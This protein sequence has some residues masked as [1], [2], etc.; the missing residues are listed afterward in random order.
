MSPT[1]R[2][3]LLV[4]VAAVC[5]LV[6]P[7][8][9]GLVFVAVAAAAVVD[10]RLVGRPARPVRDVP[11][12][13]SRG[14]P[15]R[16]RLRPEEAAQGRVTLRQP[17][18]AD[19]EVTPSEHDDE[20]AASLTVRRR[21]RHLLPPAA[22][23]RE[24]PLG[25]AA[26]YDGS[27]RPAE[28]KVYP[29]LVGA[30]RLVARLRARQLSQAARR[31]RG[32]LGLGTDFESVRDYSPDDDIRQVNWQ[33]TAR[34]ARPMSNQY[35]IEHDRDVICLVDAGRLMGAPLGERTR[36]DAAVDAVAALAAVADELED[37]CGVTV[38]DSGVRR[39][40]PP[41][42]KGGLSVVEAVYDVE[43]SNQDADYELAFR[44]V[45]RDKRALVV[46]LTDLLDEAAARSLVDAAPVLVRRH[47]VVIASPVDTDLRALIT[48][49]PRTALDAY[50]AA[51]TSMVLDERQRVRTRLAAVGAR[52][53][54]AEP[55]RLGA[56]CVDAYLSAKARARL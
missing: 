38:F 30:R 12:T 17:A 25:L 7:L 35:R 27:G 26:R 28:V 8:L 37:R 34:L 52:V 54:E 44:L 49:T 51:A 4:A 31:A 29:D 33:A 42:R 46:V 36:L 48:T 47:A 10:A 9:G 53:V 2:A 16:L 24:G 14:R 3:A 1:P 45:G 21:G 15:A 6:S 56:V 13:L 11:A 39:N 23:R 55:A 50:R 41:R 19:V 18:P 22:Q 40:V 43:P 32:P 5:A 20:L